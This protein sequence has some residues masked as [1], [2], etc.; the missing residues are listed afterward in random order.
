MADGRLDWGLL[1]RAAFVF[2]TLAFVA[3]AVLSVPDLF[4][5]LV[6]YR[7]YV[8]ISVLL[9]G[10]LGLGFKHLAD[11]MAPRLEQ[12]GSATGQAVQKAT[13]VGF[14]NELHEEGE[15]LKLRART[16]FRLAERK[17]ADHEY[18]ARPVGRN[19]SRKR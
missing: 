16:H 14:E 13:I 9:S 18:T 3:T 12:V 1:S 2:G 10:I 17:F 6:S 15:E 19:Q 7:L 5:E 8:F 11:L 4:P